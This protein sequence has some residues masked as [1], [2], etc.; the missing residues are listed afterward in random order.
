MVH[1]LQ[2]K[3][4]QVFQEALGRKTFTASGKGWQ[5]LA[6]LE[7]GTRNRRLYCPYGPVCESDKA[8]EEALASLKAL[9]QEQNA[10]FIRVEPT[11][12][13]S[14]AAV[15]ELGLRKMTYNKLQPEQTQIIQLA[16]RS[17]DDVLAD[18]TSS[19]RNRFRN[20]TKKG[21]TMHESVNPED[22]SI[23]LEFIHKVADRTGLRPHSDEYFRSQTATLFPLGAGK[24]FYVMFEDKPVAASI[25]FEGDDYRCYAHAAADDDYR[26]LAP[27]T[28]LVAHMIMDAH[29]RGLREYDLYGIAPNSPDDDPKHAWAGF[30]RFKQQFGGER[31]QYVGTWDLPINKTRYQLY[32]L[33]QTVRNKHR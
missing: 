30:T 15:K 21:L 14:A 32:K 23:F 18:M 27:G 16:G 22:V 19:T 3:A 24:L 9:A 12:K 13:V 33:Y 20:Y 5:Y 29:A 17:A 10:D 11:G 4:W 25:S 7:T 6:V 28:I 8:L 26:N 1:F 2:T 31:R